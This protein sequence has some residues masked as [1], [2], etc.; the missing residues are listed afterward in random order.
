MPE[1]QGNGFGRDFVMFV[2]AVTIVVVPYWYDRRLQRVDEKMQMVLTQSEKTNQMTLQLVKAECDNRYQ[3]LKTFYEDY[4]K[5]LNED[6]TNR[7]HRMENS[8]EDLIYHLEEAYKTKVSR[9]GEKIDVSDSSGNKSCPDGWVSFGPSCYVVIHT[10]AT[11]PAAMHQCYDL[12]AKLA[13]IETEKERNF[14]VQHMKDLKSPECM[15]IGGSDAIIEGQWYWM[16]SQMT[17]TFADWVEGEPNNDRGGEDCVHINPN[18]D[19][20]WNDAKCTIAY[21]FIC[22]KEKDVKKRIIF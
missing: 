8:Y 10:V 7:V 3:R 6:Q 20:H 19:Y 2:V 5:R 14:I 1:G 12:N 11:M 18:S 13:E 9:K 15:W 17:F 22:E 21:K 16:T 4:I